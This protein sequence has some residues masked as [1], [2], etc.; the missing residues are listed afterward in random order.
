MRLKRTVPHDRWTRLT[1]A[2]FEHKGHCNI[3]CEGYDVCR[4]YE[5]K[6]T[7][8]GIKPIK[9]A[10]ILTYAKLGKPKGV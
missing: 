3:R 6:R 10:M 7:T 1:I 5:G 8:F 9:W 4:K 2:C